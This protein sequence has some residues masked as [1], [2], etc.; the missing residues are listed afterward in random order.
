MS[1]QVL[2]VEAAKNAKIDVI[3]N[4]LETRLVL[5]IAAGN[6]D[7]DDRL[8]RFQHQGRTQGDAWPLAGSN[9]VRVSGPCIQTD[10]PTPM[11]DARISCRTSGAAQSARRCCHHISPAVHY[12][13]GR[14]AALGWERSQRFL[15]RLHFI[16]IARTKF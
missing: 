4:E 12:G 14:G 16:R 15:D 13:K 11:N 2:T 5:Q 9:D 1:A 10:Q 8:S 3:E 6:A 7:G